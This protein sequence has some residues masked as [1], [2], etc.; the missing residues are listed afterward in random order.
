MLQP[1]Q[2]ISP[3]PPLSS[4]PLQQSI[5]S[6]HPTQP[7]QPANTSSAAG[8]G[9]R[10]TSEIRRTAD[11]DLSSYPTDLLD[12][13]DRIATD[14]RIPTQDPSLKLLKLLSFLMRNRVPD[15]VSFADDCLNWY[16][17][18]YS[19]KTKQ[20]QLNNLFDGGQPRSQSANLEAFGQTRQPTVTLAS[21]SNARNVSSAQT[22]RASEVIVIPDGIQGIPV[23]EIKEEPPSP[24]KEP[25]PKVTS[26]MYSGREELASAV[27]NRWERFRAGVE[28]P[29]S[30]RTEDYYII[31]KST[32]ETVR[33]PAD[34]CLSLNMLH[35]KDDAVCNVHLDALR[36][37]WQYLIVDSCSGAVFN[38]AIG[39]P[40]AQLVLTFCDLVRTHF[41]KKQKNIVIFCPSCAVDE[42][43]KAARSCR[44]VSV[45]VLRPDTWA[46]DAEQWEEQRGILLCPFE[47]YLRI[48][49]APAS[50]KEQRTAATRLLCRPGPSIAI[51]DEAS[52]LL[53]LQPRLRRAL[54]RTKTKSRLAVTNLPRAHNTVPFWGIVDWAAPEFL[55]SLEEYLYIFVRNFINCNNGKPGERCDRNGAAVET[56]LRR[57][58]RS[59][60][61]TVEGEVRNDAL[62]RKG[63]CLKET[64]IFLKL[65]REHK[66]IYEDV[67]SFMLAARKRGEVSEYVAMHVLLLASTSILALLQLLRN[68]LEDDD[69][70]C[71]D[72]GRELPRVS[73]LFK[74]LHTV[75]QESVSGSISYA[76]LEVV[77]SLCDYVTKSEGKLAVFSAM[78]EVQE[79]VVSAIK[80]HGGQCEVF[81]CDLSASHTERRG[82]IHSFNTCGSPGAVLLGPVGSASDC[83]EGAGWGAVHA[84]HVVVVDS[85]W[86]E[87]MIPQ[88]INR[89]YNF[90]SRI[91][92]QVYHL[93]AVDTVECGLHVSMVSRGKQ[94]LLLPRISESSFEPRTTAPVEPSTSD[95]S[96]AYISTIARLQAFHHAE[97][98]PS[99]YMISSNVADTTGKADAYSA[100]LYA[101]N[102]RKE[103]FR[104]LPKVIDAVQDLS[105]GTNLYETLRSTRAY[106]AY[107]FLQAKS[108][109]RPNSFLSCWND[110]FRL[111]EQKAGIETN[112]QSLE[113]QEINDHSSEGHL[114]GDR[115]PVMLPAPTSNY[116]AANTRKRN[117]PEYTADENS[118]GYP[119]K[120]R[121][122]RP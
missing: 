76:K 20:Q 83:V 12:S 42:W 49:N 60:V 79:E 98:S 120:R 67:A 19:R 15:A 69:M 25:L 74:E 112:T 16:H 21:N 48:L 96:D 7:S 63:Q 13:V 58:F 28:K 39:Y 37:L 54:S 95:E 51:V 116:R 65:S 72:M 8:T 100:E 45:L 105:Y 52:R 102:E 57:L 92:V 56:D 61:F 50:Q 81:V 113:V 44:G 91:E 6:H 24:P 22:N 106:R 93:V 66:K 9:P 36:F 41:A 94:S 90:A 29:S 114:V 10:D 89:V 31:W 23:I 117:S 88:G 103:Y 55:G 104:L 109:Q 87:T 11:R 86:S 40:R 119:N 35:D 73:R 101:A 2:I 18:R 1:S 122:D 75:V 70:Q 121:V 97:Q 68:G 30:H 110:Y 80:A 99:R 46:Q 5:P 38:P 17:S 43:Q 47:T 4:I 111:Y 107:S 26:R 53:T 32:K 71:Y 85:T 33:L 59:V 62:I 64:T 34:Y 115:G 118:A 78:P 84:S 27:K 77:L 3:G 108:S 82:Q 14:Q